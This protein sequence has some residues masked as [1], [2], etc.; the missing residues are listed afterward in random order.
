MWARS[1]D[2]LSSHH[3]LGLHHSFRN[4]CPMES[5]STP[6]PSSTSP[7]N[8]SAV[9]TPTASQTPVLPP[10]SVATAPPPAT[11]P[12]V[13][14]LV[15]N[16]TELGQ[17]AVGGDSGSSTDSSGSSTG[18]TQ[19]SGSRYQYSPRDD[20]TPRRRQRYMQDDERLDVIWRVL[21]GERQSDLAREYQ[22]TRAAI[23]NTFKN[24]NEILRRAQQQLP[25]VAPSLVVPM[26][27]A[28]LPL[29]SSSPCVPESGRCAPGSEHCA[30]DSGGYVTGG[31][32]Y[33][34]RPDFGIVSSSNDS[35]GR[36][37]DSDNSY[38]NSVSSSN[39]DSRV[40]SSSNARTV[41]TNVLPTFASL[42]SEQPRYVSLELMLE[43]F[44][45][46]LTVSVDFNV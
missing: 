26:V 43:R 6:T 14:A 20:R 12:V 10:S 11:A 40:S 18:S 23:C 29:E 36:S 45:T 27:N 19:S 8:A 25:S 4:D 35:R 3:H 2:P 17:P 22:V 34:T 41:T 32:L 7:S 15:V 39:S 21:N 30:P 13:V 37:S 16:P 44:S 28:A 9:P 38:S 46:G 1:F 31:R 33:A 24:R 5:N 42:R